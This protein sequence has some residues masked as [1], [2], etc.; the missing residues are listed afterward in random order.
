[1]H[2]YK[3]KKNIIFYHFV[4]QVK[5][6]Y[7]GL[8]LDLGTESKY[9]SEVPVAANKAAGIFNVHSLKIVQSHLI[10]VFEIIYLSIATDSV[11]RLGLEFDKVVTVH[12]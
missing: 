5:S 12:W 11:L 2:S 4:Y 1:M 8:C 3:A 9:F 10:W 7:F 6:R